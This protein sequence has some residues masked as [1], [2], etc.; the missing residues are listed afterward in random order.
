[1]ISR[2]LATP[3][4]PHIFIFP[5]AIVQEGSA[6]RSSYPLSHQTAAFPLLT[7]A[8]QTGVAC[9]A[10]VISVLALENRKCTFYVADFLIKSSQNYLSEKIWNT[11]LC[12]CELNKLRKIGSENFSWQRF[13]HE[14]FFRMFIVLLLFS[15]QFTSEG[16]GCQIQACVLHYQIVFALFPI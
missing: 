15:A 9:C 3:T 16:K 12:W 13:A 6:I 14:I 10:K 1:M 8:K 11:P 7:R 4:H 5:L 2:H